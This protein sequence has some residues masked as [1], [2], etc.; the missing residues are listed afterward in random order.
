MM[1]DVMPQVYA[2]LGRASTRVTRVRGERLAEADRANLHECRWYLRTREAPAVTI[3]WVRMLL[4]LEYETGPEVKLSQ[5][6][7]AAAAPP[8]G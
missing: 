3:E 4:G 6:D 5:D 2:E 7:Y 1:R 8:D